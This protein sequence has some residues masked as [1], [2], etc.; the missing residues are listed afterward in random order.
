MP[1]S[2][3]QK[4]Q[5]RLRGTTYKLVRRGYLERQA[6]SAAAA[7]QLSG[8]PGASEMEWVP[9]AEMDK[10]YQNIRSRRSHQPPPGDGGDGN[11]FLDVRHHTGDEFDLGEDA[12]YWEEEEEEEEGFDDD[13][14]EEGTWEDDDEAFD[15]VFGDGG[16]DGED[17]AVEEGREGKGAGDDGGESGGLLVLA[18]EYDRRKKLRQQPAQ[19][20]VKFTLPTS[21]ATPTAGASPLSTPVATRSALKGRAPSGAEAGPAEEAEEEEEA[22]DELAERRR[23]DHRAKGGHHHHHRHH[24]HDE[25]NEDVD[26][27]ECEYGAADYDDDEPA[28]RRP[29]HKDYDGGDDDDKLFEDEVE[30]EVTDEFLRQLVFGTGLTGASSSSSPSMGGGGRRRGGEDDREE[31]EFSLPP[32]MDEE[33]WNLLNEEERQAVMAAQQRGTRRRQRR[34]TAL[35]QTHEDPLHGEDEGPEKGG[36]LRHHEL[37]GAEGEDSYP[38]HRDRRALE[39]QFDAMMAEFENDLTINDFFARDDEG[40]STGTVQH[41]DP[42]TAGALS[43]EKYSSALE[44]FVERRAGIDLETNEPRKNKGLVTQLKMLAYRAGPF[45]YDA[46]NHGV[47]LTNNVSNK[48]R[49]FVE[50]FLAEKE[51]IRRAAKLRILKRMLE[52]KRREENGLPSLEEEEERADIERALSHDGKLPG[53]EKEETA[54]EVIEVKSRRKEDRL[55]CETAVS[56]YSSYYNQP[57]VIRAPP[58][59]RRGGGTAKAMKGNRM[60]KDDTDDDSGNDHEDESNGDGQPS[61]T[62]AQRPDVSFVREKMETK[63]EKKLRRQAVKQL[64]RERRQEKSNLKKA[65]K[66]VAQEEASRVAISQNAKRTISFL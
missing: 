55:D 52:N 25:D 26:H 45:D 47:F 3:Y 38:T 41:A 20:T 59:K 58:S 63:E 22:F 4:A 39:K 49:K 43:I 35:G 57:N 51:E 11:P 42:R 37:L 2:K 30:C 12:D 27:P 15:E 36:L 17:N 13:G 64:Q 10:A 16:G 8:A 44:E 19:K 54:F 60:N 9:E 66:A 34:A 61:S 48:Q 23:D 14:K 1:V 29:H 28:N 31:E 33:V 7:E 5:R 6:E 24:S 65:Y 56:A 21:H 62:A 53:H 18:T 46:D 32:G 50:E 40:N